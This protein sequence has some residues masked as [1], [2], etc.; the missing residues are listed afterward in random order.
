MLRGLQSSP[1]SEVVDWKRAHEPRDLRGVLRRRRAAAG[2][3]FDRTADAR[4]P[5]FPPA[6]TWSFREWRGYAAAPSQLWAGRIRERLTASRRLSP[7][8]QVPKLACA[9]V[10]AAPANSQSL[11]GGRAARQG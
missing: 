1:S 5:P 10:E 3:R 6:S 11:R 8:L 4:G 9:G 2:A 7:Y